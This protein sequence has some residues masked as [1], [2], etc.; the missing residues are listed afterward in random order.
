VAVVIRA[1]C[2]DAQEGAIDFTA[3]PATLPAAENSAPTPPPEDTSRSTEPAAKTTAET[4]EHIAPPAESTSPV[5][6]GGDDGTIRAVP[7]SIDTSSTAAT[8]QNETAS[9]NSL[10]P[11]ATEPADTTAAP[12]ENQSGPLRAPPLPETAASPENTATDTA[13]PSE[14]STIPARAD[15]L[16]VAGNLD[17]AQMLYQSMIDDAPSDTAALM[18]LARIAFARKRY[19]ACIDLIDRTLA[20][21]ANQTLETAF[22]RGASY[23]RLGRYAEAVG[24]LSKHETLEGDREVASRMRGRL[25]VYES[26]LFE[27]LARQAV[28]REAPAESLSVSDTVIAV[29]TFADAGAP[30][31]LAPLRTGLADMII[32]DLSQ[33]EALRVVE[34][35]RAHMLQQELGLDQ[36]GV[37]STEERLRV[38][39]LAGAARVVAGAFTAPDSTT[40]RIKGGFID[41]K[42]GTP[43]SAEPVGGSLEQLFALEKRF[44][45]SLIDKLGITLTDRER[46]QIRTVPT[47]NLL[48]YLAYAEGLAMADGGRFAR[49]E[50]SFAEAARLD[51]SFTRAREQAA[52]MAEAVRTQQEPPPPPEAAGDEPMP[53]VY[54]GSGPGTLRKAEQ[55]E[56]V[57]VE[58]APV[59]VSTAALTPS[60]TTG[61][62]AGGGLGRHVSSM[63]GAAFM[64]ELPVDT[65]GGDERTGAAAERDGEPAG[66]TDDVPVTDGAL[67]PT[68]PDYA[69][70]RELGFG[71]GMRRVPIIV[72]LPEVQ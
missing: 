2:A 19:E 64:N 41:V 51:P 17:S 32:T 10:S 63:T 46:R 53:V 65:R 37:T 29:V 9:Q 50:A 57:S 54:E 8:G 15:S 22:L 52:A 39:R 44:V 43:V 6:T 67:N 25:A 70:Y 11:P 30:E 47:E 5:Y 23:G 59:A 34:R 66:Q 26:R 13:R 21:G 3:T 18:G 35:T 1:A 60:A 33:V 12:L 28:A 48:A 58:A 56:E 61:F 38:A 45:F 40:I 72:E 16:Y 62:N 36:A 42:T 69:D 55:A 20:S 4:T 27:T 14:Q 71:A 24:E 31:R 68:R 7:E 49:A